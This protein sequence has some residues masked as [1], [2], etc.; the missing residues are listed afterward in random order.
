MVEG[1]SVVKGSEALQVFEAQYA[2]VTYLLGAIVR[3]TKQIGK[4]IEAGY[5]M[6]VDLDEIFNSVAQRL[7]QSAGALGN[8]PYSHKWCRLTNG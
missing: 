5:N 7:F 2:N 3:D 6:A 4:P 8:T 1:R